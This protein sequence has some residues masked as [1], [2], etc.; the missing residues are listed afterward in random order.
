[1]AGHTETT[2]RQRAL[3]K[4]ERRPARKTAPTRESCLE[5]LPQ[6]PKSSLHQPGR[7]FRWKE[8]PSRLAPACQA[9]RARMPGYGDGQ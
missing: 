9:E 7:K 2:A 1:L 5:E 3:A 8:R 4:Q 6:P